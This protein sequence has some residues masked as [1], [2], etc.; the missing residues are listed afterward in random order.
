VG[1]YF[2]S[3]INL[4]M[5]KVNA[6]MKSLINM[7]TFGTGFPTMP[8]EFPKTRVEEKQVL[9]SDVSQLSAELG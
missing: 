9:Y 3:N 7:F 1:S 6:A 4:A 5:Y 8:R 2:V